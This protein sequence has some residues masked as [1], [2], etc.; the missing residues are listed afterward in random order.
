M[1]ARSKIKQLDLIPKPNLECGGS[2]ENSRKQ[3]RTLSS[4][5]PMHLVLKA[6]KITLFRN[7]DFIQR[8]LHKQSQKFGHRILTWSVQRNHIHLLIRIWDRNSY[9]KFIRALTGLIARKLGRGLWKFRPFTRVL[10]WGREIWNVN[11]YIFK[12][13][14]EVFGFWE[15]Q[16]RRKVPDS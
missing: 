2:L 7:R 15:Y 14:M 4:K 6:N 10:S 11:N 8:T 9:I 1:N 5:K 16:P 12:N 13:E 3:K